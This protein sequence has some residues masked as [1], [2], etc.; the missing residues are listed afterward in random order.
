MQS[1]CRQTLSWWGQERKGQQVGM[2]QDCRH[3]LGQTH[4]WCSP[5][6]GPTGSD[7]SSVAALS[8]ATTYGLTGQDFRGQALQ[9][10]ALESPHRL[11]AR[12]VRGVGRGLL[13][14]DS[15]DPL[16]AFPTGASSEV[17]SLHQPGNV[18]RHE[19]GWNQTISLSKSVTGENTETIVFNEIN[20]YKE[21]FYICCPIAQMTKSSC[22]PFT[23]VS[24]MSLN[25]SLS[26]MGR[27]GSLTKLGCILN[28]AVQHL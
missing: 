17:S 12:C 20:V 26:R 14:P 16:P 7:A 21:I 11:P 22:N 23:E 10:Q 8:S 25:K 15:L 6:H 5:V 18:G 9:G 24:G 1:T 19:L 2:S 3:V 28:M 13:S 27:A 4:H